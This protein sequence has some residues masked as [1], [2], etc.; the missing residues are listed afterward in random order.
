MQSTFVAGDVMKYNIE[1]IG[2]LRTPYVD[3]APYQ[4]V[5]DE[6]GDFRIVVNKE[7]SEGLCEL[8]KLATSM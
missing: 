1:Q 6:E 8:E 5:N 2:I 4:P 3:N 7:Y